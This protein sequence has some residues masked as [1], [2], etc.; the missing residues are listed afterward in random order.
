ML[1]N[2]TE[3]IEPR[4]ILQEIKHFFRVRYQRK[5]R[6]SENECDKFLESINVTSLSEQDKVMI[7]NPITLPELKQVLKSMPRNKTPGK[8]GLPAEFYLTFF[9]ILGPILL[10]CINEN[11]ENFEKG[12]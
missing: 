12:I 5:S 6:I 3:I 8:D 7:D 2:E 1:E 9:N 10:K 4:R 11:F